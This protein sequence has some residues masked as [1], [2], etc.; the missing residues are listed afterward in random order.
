[1]QGRTYWVRKAKDLTSPKALQQAV[2]ALAN[3]FSAN[4]SFPCFRRSRALASIGFTVCINGT[5]SIYVPATATYREVRCRSVG[6]AR[7][8]ERYLKMRLKG[9]CEIL[10]LF[11]AGKYI[12]HCF[13]PQE[14]IAHRHSSE[15]CCSC[16]TLPGIAHTPRPA[17]QQ[18]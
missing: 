16:P 8:S 14:E 7:H 18:Q 17:R 12:F 5:D 2:A 13:A 3:S 15:C 4:S 1:M 11:F 6:S 10:K 9:L